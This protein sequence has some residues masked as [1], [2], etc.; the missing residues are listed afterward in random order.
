M[1]TRQVDTLEDAEREIVEH[2]IKGKYCTKP[3]KVIA[4]NGKTVWAYSCSF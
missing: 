1:W 4:P 2:N 3:C